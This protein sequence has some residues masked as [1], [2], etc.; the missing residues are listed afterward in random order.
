MFSVKPLRP[1]IITL[2]AS[3]FL[4]LGFNLVLWQHLADI[5]TLDTRGWLMCAAFAVML[6]CGFNLVLTLLAFR[7]VLK[8]VL[9]LL[10]LISAGVAYFMSQ[11][12]VLIDAAMFRNFAETNATEVRDLLS[13]K[14]LA[15]VLLLGVLPCW[16]VW[17]TPINYRRWHREVL[18][19]VLVSVASVAVIGGVALI[20]YQGLSSLFRAEQLRRCL[21]WLSA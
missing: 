15:Y 16:L 2:I 1:E 21:H 5:V 17:K 6:L 14:L 18:S 4:L 3:A 9:M 11:Y 13:L 8:P 12:G 10:F 7:R 20:N 19:K